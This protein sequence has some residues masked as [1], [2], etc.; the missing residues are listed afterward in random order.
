MSIDFD[1]EITAIDSQLQQVKGY[2][3]CEK[4][5]LQSIKRQEDKGFGDEAIAAY[6]T[7]LST[8]FHKKMK[9]GNGH[10]DYTNYMFTAGCVDYLLKM[11]PI[12]NI[13]AIQL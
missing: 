7:K 10:P 13:T 5:I 8:W 6:L 1:T 2:L 4:T 11:A 12:K 3:D 9:M